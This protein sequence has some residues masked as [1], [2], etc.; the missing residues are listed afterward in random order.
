MNKLRYDWGGLIA[1]IAVLDDFNELLKT[2][3]DLKRFYEHLKRLEETK[4]VEEVKEVCSYFSIHNRA[5]INSKFLDELCEACWGDNP[6]L[7]AC[8]LGHL[9][10]VKFLTERGADIHANNEEA[11]QTAGHFGRVEVAEW[12]IDNGA[13]ML[14][15]IKKIN[16]TDRMNYV[17][18][19]K[20][21]EHMCYPIN[22]WH[23]ESK[24]KIMELFIKKGLNIH[25][26]CKPPF[27]CTLMSLPTLDGVNLCFNNIESCDFCYGFYA[28]PNR[29]SCWYVS[30]DVTE[31]IDNC[32]F[33]NRGYKEQIWPWPY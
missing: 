28:S 19:G 3:N 9:N 30:P 8:K 5:Y 16:Y 27:A 17:L 24:H 2:R 12:L 22:K 31:H 26:I 13:D 10:A 18:I 25:D 14:G 15:M 33:E 23:T 20:P 4:S 7:E 6:L 11:L 32:F 21:E 1:E 29:Q